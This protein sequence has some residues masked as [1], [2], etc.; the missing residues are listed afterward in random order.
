MKKNK[1]YI[2]AEIGINHEGS[3]NKALKLVDLAKRAGADAV[4]FQVFEP[5]TLARENS[6]K[7]A[8]QKKYLKKKLSL[9]KMWKKMSLE[10]SDLKKLKNKC[11]KLKI[12]FICSIF[13]QKS[14]KKVKA[15]KPKFIK[16][17]SSEINNLYLLH[18]I[19]KT[20]KKIILSTGLADDKEIMEAIKIFGKNI[21]ILHCVSSYPCSINIAN[22]KRMISIKKKFDVEV[23]YSDHVI[24]NHACF[25]A[26]SLGA[27]IIEKH[28]TSNKKLKGADHI[29]S[30]DEKDLREIVN[31]ARNFE[32]IKGHGKIKPSSLET[33]NKKLFRKGLYYSS[34]LRKG[35]KLNIADILFARPETNFK[36][37]DYK[38]LLGLKLKRNVRKY[39][40][41]EKKDF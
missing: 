10:F 1:V 17:A 5:E 7:T 2:I 3:V 33:V 32:K 15:L 41:I 24:G 39:N 34:D 40:S 20:K 38:K 35:S 14:L 25:I 36:V 27:K 22:I 4:K 18:L 11:V 26:I 8:Q 31:F 23:G 29:L 21:Y 12:D 30:A 28:F 19:K 13:D 37:N 9:A 16:V 6:K